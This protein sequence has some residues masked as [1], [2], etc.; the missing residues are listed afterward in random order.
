MNKIMPRHESGAMREKLEALR[1]DFMPAKEVNEAYA[2]VATHGAEKYDVDNWVKGLPTS[3]LSASLQRHLWSYM[4]GE[5][6]DSDSGLCHL[7]HILWNAVA[8]VYF[9]ENGNKFDD[10]FPN[11]LADKQYES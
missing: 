3:Q 5:D 1:Y 4:S 11:R 10:R 7:D 8:L 9:R 2:R 6:K